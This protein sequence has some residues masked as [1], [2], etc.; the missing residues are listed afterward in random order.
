V[1]VGAHQV[2]Q[3]AEQLLGGPGKRIDF[4]AP[5]DVDPENGRRD[6]K[7][8]IIEVFSTAAQR[9]GRVSA[10]H[11][12]ERWTERCAYDPHQ[13]PGAMTSFSGPTSAVSSRDNAI[14][15]CF[16]RLYDKMHAELVRR[17]TGAVVPQ[18]VHAGP[19]IGGSARAGDA[20][21]PG[22]VPALGGLG[23]GGIPGGSYRLGED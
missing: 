12:I 10:E 3:L 16:M 9:Q 17:G 2:R 13:G 14:G 1:S 18:S 21:P 5:V 20:T 15:T 22:A 7:L 4:E 23:D 6:Y 8:V 11:K 19:Q